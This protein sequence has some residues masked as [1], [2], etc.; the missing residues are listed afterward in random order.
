MFG[1]VCE[2]LGIEGHHIPFWTLPFM[3][4]ASCGL[5]WFAYT[6]RR[7]EWITFSAGDDSCV[8]FPRNGPDSDSF[9]EFT[10]T[11]IQHITAAKNGEQADAC[12]LPS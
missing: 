4:L 8:R 11:L 9:S 1:S 3:F 10:A 12:E 7:E 6:I 2:F 5:L